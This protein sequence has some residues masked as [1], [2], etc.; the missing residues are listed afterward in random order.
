ME[1]NKTIKITLIDDE[2][3]ITDLLDNYFKNDPLISVEGIYNNGKLFFEDLNNGTIQ[4]EI[5]LLDLKMKEMNG[6]EVTSILKENFP[7]IKIIIMSS[8]YKTSFMGF[9]LKSGVNAF[10][11]KGISLEKLSDIIREVSKNDFY[12]MKEHVE[13][14]KQQISSKV[15]QPKF[16]EKDK[17]TARELEVLN[18]ICLQYTTQ[19][20]ADKLFITVRT[21]EGH[22]SN[23]LL[24]SGVKNMAGLIIWAVQNELI[25]I[26]DFQNFN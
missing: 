20:I 11:P 7:T 22:R 21:V 3:L 13:I 1:N 15:P 12:F 18:L 9:M 16:S 2:G 24:K 10:I 5:I 8:Y 6:M 26:N 19:E 17:L 25:D 14:M 4:P 23:L